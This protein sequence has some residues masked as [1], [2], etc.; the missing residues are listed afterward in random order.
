MLICCEKKKLFHGGLI[1][2]EQSLGHQRFKDDTGNF[3]NK[4]I[5]QEDSYSFPIDQTNKL[6][7]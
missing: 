4:K 5:T 1:L 6:D 3:K 2:A 7:Y